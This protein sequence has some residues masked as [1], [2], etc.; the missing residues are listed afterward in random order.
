MAGA[1]PQYRLVSLRQV[2]EAILEVSRDNLNVIV[3]K[4]GGDCELK[5]FVGN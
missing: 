4:D 3:G 5:L 1:P 2:E